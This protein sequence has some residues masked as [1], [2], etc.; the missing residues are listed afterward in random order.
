MNLPRF[1]GHL[2]ITVVVAG[3]AITPDQASKLTPLELCEQYY[4][5]NRGAAHNAVIYQEAQRRGSGYCE[6]YRDVVV[7]R[8]QSQQAAN[9]AL[10]Q[11]LLG[12]AAVY[13][14]TQPPVQPIYLQQNPSV[15]CTVNRNRFGDQIYCR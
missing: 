12:A 5:I 9:A 10:G 3:C 7:T 4:F 6:A 11:A 2:F 13:N 1:V 8:W 14:L 15:Q